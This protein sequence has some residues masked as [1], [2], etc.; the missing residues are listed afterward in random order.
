MKTS[1]SLSADGKTLT[2]TIPMRFKRQGGRKLIV[3]PEGADSSL[4]PDSLVNS[5]LVNAFARA[6]RWQGMIESGE[7]A[8]IT[9]LA[10]A[11]R[12]NRSYLRRMLRLTLLAPDMVE[13][14]LDG[15][16]PLNLQLNHLIRPFSAIWD[17]QRVHL[18]FGGRSERAS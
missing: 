11:E 8:T 5:I 13:A 18:G 14:I 15:R 16:Q 12:V 17:E 4:P 7:F 2:V 3:L 1:M 9:E 6:H 10:Q